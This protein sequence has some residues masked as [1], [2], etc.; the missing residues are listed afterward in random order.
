M[1]LTLNFNTSPS[2]TVLLL[3]QVKLSLVWVSMFP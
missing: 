2:I 1:V 3:G